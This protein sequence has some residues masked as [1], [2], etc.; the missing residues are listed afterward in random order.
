MTLFIVVL[1]DRHT[2]DM[3]HVCDNMPLAL[4]YCTEFQK[5][6]RDRDELWDFWAKTS[7]GD[8]PYASTWGDGCA[9][10]IRTVDLNG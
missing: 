8:W 9:A 4:R 10:H 1:K 3:L 6:Y 2:D 7:D 5:Q